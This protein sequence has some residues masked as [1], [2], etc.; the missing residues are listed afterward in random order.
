MIILKYSSQKKPS[1]AQLE[2]HVNNIDI[3]SQQ[4]EYVAH[5]PTGTSV[6]SGKFNSDF[7]SSG[8]LQSLIKLFWTNSP[9]HSI[10][11]HYSGGFGGLPFSN[12]TGE[13]TGFL[14]VSNTSNASCYAFHCTVNYPAI[15]TS[16]PIHRTFQPTSSIFAS[17]IIKITVHRSYYNTHQKAMN[18]SSQKCLRRKKQPQV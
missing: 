9:E 11:T 4:V 1:L 7:F 8:N 15:W 17:I 6:R 14:L 18:F 5:L 2:L 16:W 12:E 13:Q 10:R 3:F